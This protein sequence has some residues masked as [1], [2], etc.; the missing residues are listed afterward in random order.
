M[1]W[2]DW[3]LL[4]VAWHLFGAIILVFVLGTSPLSGV[5]TIAQGFEFVNPVFIYK[6]SNVNWFGAAML[7]LVYGS[8]L[9]ICTIGY[10][11]YKLCIVGRK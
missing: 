8:L 10:W 7:C 2:L 3:L 4:L 1:L 5:L 11:I 9:P 6:H